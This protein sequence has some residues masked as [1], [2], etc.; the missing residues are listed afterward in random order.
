VYLHASKCTYC[1][2][3]GLPKKSNIVLYTVK[4]RVC[5]EFKK[6]IIYFLIITKNIFF[7]LSEYDFF[8]DLK[9]QYFNYDTNLL[10]DFLIE[11]N[12]LTLKFRK[13]QVD[14][15]GKFVAKTIKLNLNNYCT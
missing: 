4:D 1:F 12:S 11:N 5:S 3:Y 7:N 14:K 13:E 8:K 10:E 15:E 9:E 6:I 2:T